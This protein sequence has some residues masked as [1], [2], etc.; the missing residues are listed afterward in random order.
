MK[1]CLESCVNRKLESR[2]E[3]G[4]WLDV[5]DE[6]AE[7]IVGTARGTIKARDFERLDSHEEGW[8]IE[9]LIVVSGIPWEPIP[10]RSDEVIPVHTRLSEEGS[11]PNPDRLSALPSKCRQ[12]DDVIDN[13]DMCD[14]ACVD[15]QRSAFVIGESA[16]QASAD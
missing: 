12:I 1:G 14:F 10:G 15:D 8:N 13:H 16:K 7:I 4:I 6:I 9:C 2:W 11:E 5:C 3:S